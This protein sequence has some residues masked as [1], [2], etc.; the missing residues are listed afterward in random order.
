MAQPAD[1]RALPIA[2]QMKVPNTRCAP[3]ARPLPTGRR[4]AGAHHRTSPAGSM[5]SPQGRRWSNAFPGSP[6]ATRGPARSG[7]STNAFGLH[8]MDGN[9]SEWVGDCWHDGYRRA[10]ANGALNPGCRTRGCGQVVVET[11]PAQCRAAWRT[12]A[13]VD[14]T[15]AHIGSGWCATSEDDGP[16][17]T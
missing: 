15:N 3:A 5:F 11:G 4:A 1:R 9:V 6:T 2:E 10:P 7:A 17:E 13:P 16:G 12:P 14:T 8:D